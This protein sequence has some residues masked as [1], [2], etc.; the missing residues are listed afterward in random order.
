MFIYNDNH[1]IKRN[2]NNF[3]INTDMFVIPLFSI[4]NFNNPFAFNDII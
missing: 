2:L 3:A 1:L 4:R